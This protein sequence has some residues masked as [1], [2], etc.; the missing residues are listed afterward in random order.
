MTDTNEDFTPEI[1]MAL[2]PSDLEK[3]MVYAMTAGRVPFVKSSPGMGKTAIVNKIAKD[4]QLEMIDC[5]LSLRDPVDLNGA[6]SPTP[7]KKKATYL[8]V[9]IFPLVDEPLPEGKNGWILF[10]DEFNTA[11]KAVQAAA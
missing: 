9:D 7:D 6:L 2:K 4:F 11:V 1:S 10:F 5:V 3:Q 8:P